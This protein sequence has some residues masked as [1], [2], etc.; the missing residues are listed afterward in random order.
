MV[1]LCLCV[2]KHQGLK[3]YWGV[4]VLIHSFLILAVD[5]QEGSPSCSGYSICRESWIGPRLDLDAGI[6]PRFICCPAHTLVA[7]PTELE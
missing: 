5:G 7:I 4:E 6:E 1:I 2:N 3:V